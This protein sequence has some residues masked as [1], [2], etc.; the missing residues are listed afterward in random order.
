MLLEHDR[1]AYLSIT[2]VCNKFPVFLY[3]FSISS[4][5]HNSK[6]HGFIMMYMTFYLYIKNRSPK[7]LVFH[8]AIFLR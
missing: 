7:Q 8:A 3:Y 2:E 4:C 6:N 1:Q 5:M